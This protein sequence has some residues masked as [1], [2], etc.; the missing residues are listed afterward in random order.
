MAGS[1]GPAVAING[2]RPDG[3]RDDPLVMLPTGAA[4]PLSAAQNLIKVAYPS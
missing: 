2:Q 3:H 1:T 4:V